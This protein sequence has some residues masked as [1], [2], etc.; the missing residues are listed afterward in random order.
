M[1]CRFVADDYVCWFVHA[2]RINDEPCRTVCRHLALWATSTGADRVRIKP[3]FKSVSFALISVSF[4]L[5]WFHSAFSRCHPASTL[6][7]H[8]RSS[9]STPTLQIASL[10]RCVSAGCQ[11]GKTRFCRLPTWGDAFLQVAN[12]GRYVFSPSSERSQDIVATMNR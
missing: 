9:K 1:E 6:V 10:G 8:E 5:S 11:P 7:L 2:L 4:G 3:G 12:L